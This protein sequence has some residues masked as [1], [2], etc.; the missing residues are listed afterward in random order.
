MNR[1]TNAGVLADM[2]QGRRV[3][4]LCQ[5][6]REAR[7]AFTGMARHVLPSETVRRANGAERITAEDGQGW[8]AFASANGNAF[9]GMSVDVVV[10]DHDSSPASLANITP[11]LAASEVGEL[12]RP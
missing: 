5:T 12:I 4:V 6:Q 9:R 7:H 10:L 1:Y 3:L 11:V 2:R 8:V